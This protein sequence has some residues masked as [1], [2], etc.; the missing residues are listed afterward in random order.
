MRLEQMDFRILG[1]LEVLDGGRTLPLGGKRQRALLALLLLHA[2]EVVASERLID[3]LWGE[4]P[5]SSAVN[6]LQAY[7]SRLRKPLGAQRLVRRPSGYVLHVEPDELDRFRFERLLEEARASEPVAARELLREALALWRGPALA[8]VAYEEFAQIEI[9]RLEELRVDA[10]ERRI[11]ADLSLEAHAA[12]VPELEAL[13]AEHPLRERLHEQLI[14]ALYRSGRQAEA[15][16]GYRR[17]RLVLVEELGIEPGPELQE[18]QRAIL[19]QDPSLTLD[20]A[21]RKP[22]AAIDERRK[23][24]SC[25]VCDVSRSAS[26]DSRDPEALREVLGR[27]FAR[28]GEIAERHGG[29]V[30]TLAGDSVM[31]VFGL[32][33]VHE[34]DAL[35]AVRA[36][37]EMRAALPELGLEGRIG[38]A[39]GEVV[40]GGEEWAVTGEAVRTATRLA[41]DGEPGG[42][43]LASETLPLVR[44]SVAVEQDGTVS[45]LVSLSPAAARGRDSPFVGREEELAAL[46]QEFE[47]ACVERTCRLATIV[48]APGIGKSRLLGE[49]LGSLDG[50]ARAAVGRCPSYGEGI[51]YRPLAEIVR[52]LAG[53]E[54][55]AAAL[56]GV[57]EASLIARRVSGALSWADTAG[58]AE[59]TFWA[60][61]RLFEALAA[62][63]PLVVVVEDVHRGEPTLLD[64]LE[65][66]AGF[67]TGMPVLLVCL[68]RPELLELRPSWATPRPNAELLALEPLAA[69]A[70]D[71]LVRLLAARHDLPEQ[72]CVRIAAAA[73]GNPLFVE[74]LVAMR[75]EQG[76]SGGAL[77]IPPTIQA[78]LAERIDQLTSEER[79]V[80]ERAAV[81]G[82]TFHRSS[83]VELLAPAARA[84]VGRSLIQLARRG[85]IR[86]DRAEFPGDDAF[87]FDHV[88]IAD[89]AYEAIPKQVRAE[90]HE[91]LVEWLEG[92]AADRLA[93][94]EEVLGHHLE[95]AYRYRSELAPADERAR[96]VAA[97]AAFYLASAGQRAYSR[98]DMPTAATLLERALALPADLGRQ[99]TD[100]GLRLAS[101]LLDLGRATDAEET[102]AAVWAA[103]G[104]RA[105]ELRAALFRGQIEIWTTQDYG[106]LRSLAEQALPHFA[107]AGDDR[108]VMEAWRVIALAALDREQYAEA[109]AAFERAVVHARRLASHVDERELLGWLEYCLFHGPT[110]VKEILRWSEE[111]S[112]PLEELEPA[113]GT[114]RA[115]LLVM[116]GRLAEARE[117]CAQA[118]ARLQELGMRLWMAVNTEF[119]WHLEMLAAEHTAA[120]EQARRGYELYREVGSGVG[121]RVTAGMLAE[122]LWAQGRDEEAVRWSEVSEQAAGSDGIGVD[123][124]DR[125]GRQVRAKVLARRG[126]L[127]AAERLAREALAGAEQTDSLRGQADALLDLAEVLERGDRGEEAAAAT[128]RAVEL[129]ERKG[130]VV[131]AERALLTSR[132]AETAPA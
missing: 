33:A 45:R 8:D 11:E 20:S 5:P 115:V 49:L 109:A 85:L 122:A 75:V 2:N 64:L 18:L 119:A 82:R 81:E 1:P 123:G 88:L 67:S 63:H 17:A 105:G 46:E 72:E 38:V 83:V 74:Q 59:E 32:P 131:L 23:L 42:V 91:R 43:L 89:A 47:R 116:A 77:T 22:P 37:A 13:V 60:F 99:R 101:A 96:A 35:R 107:E 56:A 92:R 80:I 71:R 28:M 61:R 93:E 124:A 6:T 121:M 12:V 40:T 129:Y 3:K 53:D 69:V 54:G 76:V 21:G 7:V 62:Q 97:R 58:S 125:R 128:A 132:H 65:Y 15:L 111:S 36:A 34:D 25:L 66:V 31:A 87:R 86:S 118:D 19:R 114:L 94:Y 14:L 68:A 29:V 108:G 51:T 117:L 50:R 4:R 10:L 98:D 130:I 27:Y 103:A 113:A 30:S 41:R 55:L 126:E 110:P 57:P 84:A 24:V 106:P 90:L 102:A 44:E 120:A 16:A 73:E 79:A 104:D 52:Q 95:H 39:T 78:L 100:L 26:L 70:T 9:R 127:D 112:L 48:G